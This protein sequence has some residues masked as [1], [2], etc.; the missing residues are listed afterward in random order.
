M[1]A[2]FGKH[3]LLIMGTGLLIAE[4][5]DMPAAVRKKIQPLQ[6]QSETSL[7]RQITQFV[8]TK[9]KG[10][11]VVP[12]ANVEDQHDSVILVNDKGNPTVSVNGRFLSWFLKKD[13]GATFVAS[14][15]GV[16]RVTAIDSEGNTMG[17]VAGLT[18]TK[19]RMKAMLSK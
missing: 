3:S 7:A 16:S 13:L 8:V 5:S 4:P 9:D 15:S 19:A 18:T 11:P 1:R 6:N 12:H 10:I 2:K 14:K 17:V